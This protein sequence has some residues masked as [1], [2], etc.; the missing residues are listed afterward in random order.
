[1]K[2]AEVTNSISFRNALAKA[3]RN[4]KKEKYSF[5]ETIEDVAVEYCLVPA[6]VEVLTMKLREFCKKNYLFV[7]KC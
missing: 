5:V 2:Y 4:A 6:E 7:G 3:K 1:M